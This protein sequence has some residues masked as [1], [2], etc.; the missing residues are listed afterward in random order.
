M[1]KGKLSL[2]AAERVG[3]LS[4]AYKF[5]PMQPRLHL[6]PDLINLVIILVKFK[7]FAAETISLS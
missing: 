4:A 5:P 7:S 6:L 2:Q 3:I 1:E